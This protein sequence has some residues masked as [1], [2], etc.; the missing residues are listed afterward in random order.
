MSDPVI[1]GL[2]DALCTGRSFDEDPE[3]PAV[4]KR[5]IER[6]EEKLMWE[7]HITDEQIDAAVEKANKV[8]SWGT[9]GAAPNAGGWDA[10]NK[11]GIERCG[12]GWKIGG[13]DGK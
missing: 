4:L 1:D 8:A 11:L 7:H 5:E 10:L 2:A 3:D 6:L 12:D 9:S 13:E